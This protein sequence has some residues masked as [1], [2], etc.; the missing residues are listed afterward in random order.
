MIRQLN[1]ILAY[2]SA[3][4]VV[5]SCSGVGYALVV[6][7][8][9]A[10]PNIGDKVTFWTHLRVREDALDLFGF[11]T[12]EELLLFEAMQKIQRFPAKTA[13]AVLSH[14]G[15]DGFRRAVATGDLDTLMRIPG[16]GKKSAQQ[17]L[18]EMRGKIDLSA[19][20][21]D[22]AASGLDDPTLALIELGYSE[23][24]A[25]VMVARTR[26]D[27]PAVSDAAEIIKL[28]LRKRA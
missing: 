22:D 6:P 8:N 4:E 13:L 9:A 19:L 18:L 24:D 28:S 25:K 5:V 3:D 23:S 27:N 17:V 14:C 16:I 11:L 20:P 26:R 21:G 10:L 15:P 2:K 1:G 12:R 7:S